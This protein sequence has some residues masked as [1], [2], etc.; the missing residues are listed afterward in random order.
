MPVITADEVVSISKK[1]LKTTV[2][3]LKMI[4][5]FKLYHSASTGLCARFVH[6]GEVYDAVNIVPHVKAKKIPKKFFVH[7]DAIIRG[8]LCVMKKKAF[9]DS[10]EMRPV[11]DAQVVD[12]HKSECMANQQG[13]RYIVVLDDNLVWVSSG[14][15]SPAVHAWA[16]KY[17]TLLC[18]KK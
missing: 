12:A 4:K 18:I 7:E 9:K 16:E 13:L 3:G 10:F 17:G 15:E 5:K 11:F 2:K 8:G 1:C 6:K 14:V